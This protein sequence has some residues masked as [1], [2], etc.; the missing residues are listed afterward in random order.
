MMEVEVVDIRKA[1]GDGKLKAFASVKFGGNLIV[2]GFSVLDGSKGVFVKV[3]AKVTKDGRW[4]DTIAIDD[5]LRPEVESKIMEAFDR[6]V[7]GIE[8]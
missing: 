5:F 2:R 6:E 1:N 4:L 8:A 7:D 3:P